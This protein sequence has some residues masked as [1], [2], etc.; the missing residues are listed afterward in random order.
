MTG[1]DIAFGPV[2]NAAHSEPTV[3]GA[4]F[5]IG[6]G[7]SSLIYVWFRYFTAEDEKPK[8]PIAN[9]IEISLICFVFIGIGIWEWIRALK[10]SN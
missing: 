5:A 2:Y 4:L 8:P 7:L 10:I 6:L 9:M 3:G 1:L